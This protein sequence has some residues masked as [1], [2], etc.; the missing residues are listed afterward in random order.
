MYIGDYVILKD[1]ARKTFVIGNVKTFLVVQ[2]R[3]PD[4]ETAIN[5]IIEWIMEEGQ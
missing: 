4:V 5:R 2:R 1:M 3:V